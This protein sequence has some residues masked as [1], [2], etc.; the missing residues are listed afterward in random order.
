M[1]FI[2]TIMTN[3]QTKYRIWADAQRRKRTK[4][5][6]SFLLTFFV[7]TNSDQYGVW[8][9]VFFFLPIFFLPYDA[10]SSGKER[11]YSLVWQF[12]SRGNRLGHSNGKRSRRPV[13]LVRGN[14][15]S[16]MAFGFESKRYGMTCLVRNSCFPRDS[17]AVCRSTKSQSWD[18]APFP[19]R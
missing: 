5:G 3:I 9:L 15:D 14:F 12:G 18:L 8:D 7:S 1:L 16:G 17:A 13:G 4:M 10:H 11:G 2:P 6:L 19:H